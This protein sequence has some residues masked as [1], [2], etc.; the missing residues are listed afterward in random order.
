MDTKL[1][2]NILRIAF[3][4]SLLLNLIVCLICYIINKTR[5]KNLEEKNRKKGI[6]DIIRREEKSQGYSEM[7]ASEKEVR[8][9]LRIKEL[10]R[11]ED[12]KD[13]E[14]VQDIEKLRKQ[15]DRIFDLLKEESRKDKQERINNQA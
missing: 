8:R 14:Y 5:R 4:L 3:W 15:E 1:I 11:G 2:L 10:L 7:S 12:S 6:V 13:D 9:R